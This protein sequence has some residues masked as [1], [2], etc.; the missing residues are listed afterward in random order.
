MLTRLPGPSRPSPKV[1]AEVLRRAFPAA[2]WLRPAQL[3]SLM[4]RLAELGIVGGAVCDALVGE[5]ARVHSLV[6]LTRDQRAARV[7]E[8]V[9][10]SVE[11][12]S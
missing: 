10:V 3:D 5:A 12:L 6:L 8:R 7:Y 4:V 11:F 1:A 2:A 9:G